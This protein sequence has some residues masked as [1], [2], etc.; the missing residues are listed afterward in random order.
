ML[1]KPCV[2]FTLLATAAL[3][4]AS[5]QETAPST[6]AS[7]T[8]ATEDPAETEIDITALPATVNV[9]PVQ[10]AATPTDAPS[11]GDMCFFAG[12]PPAE[13]AYTVIRKFKVGKG[14]YGGVKDILP[15]FA[16]LATKLGADAVMNYAG[17]QRFGFWPWRMV[18][19]VAQGVAIKWHTAPSQNCQTLGGST[20]ATILATD[21]APPRQQ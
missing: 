13:L 15:Q 20:L 16:E 3:A 8:T 18:R 7:D 14:S 4:F 19:P 12:T 9:V 10:T 5:T 2:A 1:K 17:S 11:L 21:K 6:P